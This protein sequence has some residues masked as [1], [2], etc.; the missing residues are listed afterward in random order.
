MYDG[1]R[2]TRDPA[3]SG[4]G[5]GGGSGRQHS[6]GDPVSLPLPPCPLRHLGQSSV[7]WQER[8]DK[9]LGRRIHVGHMTMADSD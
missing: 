3:A 9:F 8:G 7:R 5:G 4:G 6:G 1:C 2:T